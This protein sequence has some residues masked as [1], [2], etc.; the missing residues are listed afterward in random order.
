M[1][2]QFILVLIIIFLVMYAISLLLILRNIVKYVIGMKR[3][4]EFRISWFYALA[5]SVISLRVAWNILILV[6][7]GV[8]N[9]HGH[10]LDFHMWIICYSCRQLENMIGV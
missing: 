4:K 9:H 2:D 6:R 5:V 3:Y 7:K 8:S 1:R 10:G